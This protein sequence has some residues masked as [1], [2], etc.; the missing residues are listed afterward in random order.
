VL[1]DSIVHHV[2]EGDTIMTYTKITAGEGN[3]NPVPLTEG[4][5]ALQSES[6]PVEFRKVELLDLSP[7]K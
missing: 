5:I 3:T 1:G 6:H 2:M 4:R 7:K